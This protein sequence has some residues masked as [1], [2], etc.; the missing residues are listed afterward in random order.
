MGAPRKERKTGEGLAETQEPASKVEKGALVRPFPRVG[1]GSSASAGPLLPG[2]DPH[3]VRPSTPGRGRHTLRSCVIT[4]IGCD[5]PLGAR[6]VRPPGR[7][8]FGTRWERPRPGPA[9]R[10]RESG[11]KVRVC[12]PAGH[13]QR[14]A[15]GRGQLAPPPPHVPGAASGPRP[16]GIGPTEAGPRVLQLPGGLAAGPPRNL[17]RTVGGGPLPSR[18]PTAEATRGAAPPE[19]PGSG[20][21]ARAELPRGSRASPRLRWRRSIRMLPKGSCSCR[22]RHLP[23]TM[24][25]GLPRS[26]RQNWQRSELR[27]KVRRAG[28]R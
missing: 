25:P 17:R 14:H 6:S 18:L 15:P 11:R 2:P 24:A 26:F 16:P 5:F 21:R 1:C 10:V 20:A 13:T 19:V 4:G 9:R 3:A 23:G 27:S 22:R 12:A 28:G 7:A 8:S